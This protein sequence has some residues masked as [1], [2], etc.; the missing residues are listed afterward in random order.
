VREAGGYALVVDH[1]PET[2]SRLIDLADETFAGTEGFAAWLD[3][4]ADAIGAR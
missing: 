1:G 3:R 4:L 2:D